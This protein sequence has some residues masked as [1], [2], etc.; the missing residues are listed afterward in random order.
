V[1][2]HFERIERIGYENWL[3][4]Q[5]K[6]IDQNFDNIKYLEKKAGND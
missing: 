6:K 1:K 2:R 3:R 5:G 4:E